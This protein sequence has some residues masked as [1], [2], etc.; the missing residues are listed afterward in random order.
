MGRIPTGESIVDKVG[1]NRYLNHLSD[2]GDMSMYRQFLLEDGS[3]ETL[4]SNFPEISFLCVE[5]C[6]NISELDI[7]TPQYEKVLLRILEL[8][9]IKA[10]LMEK[11]RAFQAK[12]KQAIG[13]ETLSNMADNFIMA[14]EKHVES[15][16]TVFKILHDIQNE[17]SN[18]MGKK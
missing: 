15:E 10:L 9:K 5:L 11:E 1:L 7:N 13:V 17:F 3:S 18:V 6:K 12:E 14:V 16:S 2:R 4:L 8:I